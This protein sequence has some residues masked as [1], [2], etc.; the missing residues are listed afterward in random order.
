MASAITTP[1]RLCPTQ[2]TWSA[3]VEH[4]NLS[5]STASRSASCSTEVPNGA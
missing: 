1:P 3:P 2:C 4:N 5:T